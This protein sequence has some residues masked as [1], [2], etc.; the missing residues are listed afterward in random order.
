MFGE[1]QEESTDRQ[2]SAAVV[3]ARQDGLLSE[4]R[5]AARMD[6][7]PNCPTIS[8]SPA[9]PRVHLDP[10][11]SS[12]HYV[13]ALKIRRLGMMQDID[14]SVLSII[15]LDVDFLCFQG[16]PSTEERSVSL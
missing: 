1:C 13:A 2:S 15:L 8:P 6:G 7:L 3:R 5:L 4:N 14:A 16:L 9:E 12:V 11:E 10:P